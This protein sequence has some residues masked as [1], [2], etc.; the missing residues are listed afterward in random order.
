MSIYHAR[1]NRYLEDRGLKAKD[2]HK[3]WVFIGDGECDEPETLGAITVASREKLDNLIFVINCNLQRLDGPVRGNGKIIQ[4]LEA[5]FRGA[6]WNVIKVI[7]GT[8]WDPI[9]DKD[10]DGLLTKR[11]GEVVDGQYQKYSVETGDYIRKDFFGTDPKLLDIV[12]H[13][14]DESL[15]KM[16]RGGHDPNKV[17]T[18]YKAAVDFKG[19][20]TVIIAKPSKVMVWAKAAKARIFLINRRNLMPKNSKNFVHDSTFLLLTKISRRPPSSVQQKIRKK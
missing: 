12:K 20:P 2:D 15:Q 7:W 5:L 13:L 1:F 14:S 18:A 19:A 3:I 9:L 10:T 4:E 8:D 16:K 6:Q 17:Y 11:M